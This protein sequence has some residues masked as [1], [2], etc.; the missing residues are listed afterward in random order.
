MD[1]N[2]HQIFLKDRKSLDLTGV[3]KIESFN[4]EEFIVETEQG[5]MTIVGQEL[6]MRNLDVEKGELQIKGY[7]TM[8]EY[9]DHT[10]TAT[11]SMFSKLFK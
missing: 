3:V 5:Y 11:K 10:V 9:K 7:V 8:I 2:S 6:E 4:E 1:Q